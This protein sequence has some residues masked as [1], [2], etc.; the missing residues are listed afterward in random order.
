MIRLAQRLRRFARSE[1]GSMVIPFAL[2]AP[3][4]VIFMISSFELG[5]ITIRHSAL[6]RAL[7]ITVREIRLGTGTTWTH[8]QIK[9]SVCAKAEVLPGCT[10]T[11]HLEMVT[12]DMRN[13]SPPDYYPDCV[14]TA[15]SVTPQRN[16]TSGAS[17]QVMFLR[18]C[19]KFQP[20][21]PSGF[22]GGSMMIDREGYMALIASSAFVLEPE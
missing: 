11:L 21:S 4:F 6:E 12:L 5:L 15:K 1:D 3:I 9:E 19:Y 14:D 20:F 2:W 10:R 7:D 18:A 13:F 17:N 22:I 16:F 8:Q